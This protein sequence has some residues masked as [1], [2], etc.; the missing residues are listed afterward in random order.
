M[1]DINEIRIREIRTLEVPFIPDYLMR[2]PSALPSS[3]PVTVEIGTPIV[4]IPGCV[5][6]HPDAGKNKSLIE[7]D[8]KGAQTY[9]DGQVPSFN[10][11]DYSPENLIIKR[12]SPV[13]KVKA[14][15]VPETSIPVI[16]SIQSQTLKCQDDE[17]LNEEL[18]ICE[19]IVV[20]VPVE[21]EPT[22][23]EQYLPSAGEVA[24]T[25]TIA[26]TAATAA[27]VAKPIADLILKLVK[28]TIKKLVKKINDFRGKEEEIL[29][30][31]ERR[32]LQRERIEALRSLKKALGK[33]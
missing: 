2:Q 18:N 29:S 5:E 4:D 17:K 1:P 19:K 30:V 8:P 6:S 23:V 22:W 32:D 11:I 15:E 7:D 24:T 33:K 21:E 16:P 31:A 14:P 9:C 10:P 27:L 20:E 28:P 3:G 13:P 12:S 26:L 25:A